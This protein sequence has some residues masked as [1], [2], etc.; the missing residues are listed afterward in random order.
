MRCSKWKINQK[1]NNGKMIGLETLKII[2]V[3]YSVIKEILINLKMS[4]LRAKKIV[5]IRMKRWHRIQILYGV[6]LTKIKANGSLRKVIPI[7]TVLRDRLV[8]LTLQVSNHRWMI[9][10]YGQI[11]SH[12]VIK[13][14]V[15]SY[16]KS[17]MVS[18]NHLLILSI[19]WKLISYFLTDN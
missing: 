11:Q 2:L 18:S 10:K 1:S 15:S 14:T 6:S 9:I 5:V 8:L 16:T 19:I 13:S 12:W 7:S 17:K 4:A 3:H